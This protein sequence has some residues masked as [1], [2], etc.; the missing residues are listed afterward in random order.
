M[1][2]IGTYLKDERLRR[3]LSLSQMEKSTKIKQKFIDSIE[4]GV[5]SELPEFA[6]VAGF[7]RAIA[8]TLHVPE[9]N[10]AAILRRDYP[11]SKN[12]LPIGPKPDLKLKFTISPKIIA[13]FV[14][15]LFVFAFFGYL[16]YQYYRYVSPPKLNITSP[17]DDQNVEDE[18]VIMGTTDSDTTLTV[19]N[20]SILVSDTG[21]FSDKIDVASD[22]FEI[23]F[24][25][26]SR[27]GKET[28]VVRKVIPKAD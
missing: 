15:V 20:Q 23:V 21:E 13:L 28:V 2:N 16:G 22:T 5:W 3:K 7:V 17:L 19:N 9:E 6:T 1:K 24:V 11:F 18:V 4:R 27:Y 25:A 26:K 8:N 10:A 14:S 12:K